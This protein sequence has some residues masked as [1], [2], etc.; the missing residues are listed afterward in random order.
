MTAMQPTQPTQTDMARTFV[1]GTRGSRLALRQVELVSQMLRAAS[2]DVAIDVREIKTE[3]DRSNAPLSEI[4]GA[5][6]F[7]KAIEDAL[8]AGTV[9]IAVHSLKDLETELP[10]GIVLA[11]TL[12]R[13]DSRDALILGPGANALV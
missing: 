3:G 6:V 10:P 1:I 2:P 5:G 12:T 11:C 9:D 8:L 7:T 4:G 13:E